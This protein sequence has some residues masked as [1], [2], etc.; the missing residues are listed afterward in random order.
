MCLLKTENLVVRCG[1]VD[2][3]RGVS[4]EIEENRITCLIGESGAG[5]SIFA[6]AVSALLPRQLSI[7]DGEIFY[8]SVPVEYP[9]LE[10]LRGDHIF[11]APQNAA[12]S[13]N[14]VI[15]IK[16]QIRE[17]SKITHPRLLEIFE[18]LNI[19]ASDA[20][21]VLNSYPFQLSGGENRRC[22]L[23]MA[24]A[25]QPRLLILDEPTAA[26]DTHIQENLMG[27]IR[28]LQ[29]RYALTILLITHNPRVVEHI[30]D[31]L[32]VMLAGEIVEHGPPGEVLAAP[33]HEYT[34]E[35]VSCL[36]S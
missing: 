30:A 26:L 12:A 17:T 9:A 21:R 29:Q 13:L 2:L 27:L 23:A 3:L 15:K 20:G 34:R 24:I 4:V 1:P 25:Q 16:R 6:R 18:T 22:L 35:I 14:P 32:Y 11:Y 28:R 10:K 5:K 36:H 8:D 33:V 7:V 31:S 19:D